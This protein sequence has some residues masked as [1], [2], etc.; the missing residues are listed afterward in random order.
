[1]SEPR[2]S[3]PPLAGRGRLGWRHTAVG[4]LVA[5]GLYLVIN[6]NWRGTGFA[7]LLVA[8]AWAIA[9]VGRR[10]GGEYRVTPAG[11]AWRH[12]L[13]G[14]GLLVWKDVGAVTMRQGRRP[15]DTAVMLVGRSGTSGPGLVLS[16]AD[17]GASGDEALARLKD[18]L[19]GVLPRLPRDVVLDRATREWLGL[20]PTESPAGRLRAS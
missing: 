5:V 10:M 18:W 4:F 13:Y 3:P 12:P 8:A 17:L 6:G 20:G 2:S 16:G 7:C 1:M 11:I 14:P 9:A 15:E 19:E